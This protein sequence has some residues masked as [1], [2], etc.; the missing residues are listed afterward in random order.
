MNCHHAQLNAKKVEIWK[1]R[2]VQIDNNLPIVVFVNMLE[3]SKIENAKLT[4]P[5]FL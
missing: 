1:A 2:K 4:E 5:W 3:I